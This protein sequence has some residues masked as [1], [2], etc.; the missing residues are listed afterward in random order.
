MTTPFHWCRV[1]TRRVLRVG[2]SF[3]RYLKAALCAEREAGLSLAT[4][5]FPLPLPYTE[6]ELQRLAPRSRRG[7][8]RACWQEARARACNVIAMALNFMYSNRPQYPSKRD[9]GRQLSSSQWLIVKRIELFLSAWGRAAVSSDLQC[10]RKGI[11]ILE[12]IAH[13]AGASGDLLHGLDP[14]HLV[15]LPAVRARTCELGSG[16]AGPLAL[17]VLRGPRTLGR[18]G[19]RAA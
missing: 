4:A 15:P 11:A 10:G 9:L 6:R 7:R 8:R 3:S 17:K 1:L 13:L 5:L 12:E 18:P 14:Y 2:C 16:T 19:L